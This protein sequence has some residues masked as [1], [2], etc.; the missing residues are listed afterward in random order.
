MIGINGADY[1]DGRGGYNM[2]HYAFD[3]SYG[4]LGGVSV[5]L[6]TGVAVDGF[7]ST[8]M[9]VNIQRVFGTRVADKFVGSNFDDQF[10]GIQGVDY[11]DGGLGSDA[12]DY[13]NDSVYGGTAGIDVN[14]G[15]GTIKDG[16]GFTDQVTGIE[17]VS[18]TK[19]KDK[20][21][22]DSSNNTFRGLSE[23][24]SFDGGNGTDWVDYSWDV[25][26]GGKL[27]VTA[28][29]TTGLG[30]DGFGFK[31]EALSNIENLIGTEQADNFTG[32]TDSNSL[33]G[34]GG[35]DT[36]DGKAG[37]DTLY[38]GSGND[39]FVLR[40]GEANGDQILDFS[41]NGAAVG[42]SIRFV[43]Y[44]TKAQGATVF[45]DTSNP[46]AWHVRSADGLVEDIFWLQNG[47]SLH[48]SDF[49]FG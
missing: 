36:L 39:V 37:A 44:G 9:L 41:G 47:A 3:A 13:T 16:F 25:S 30:S 34:Q 5:N 1:I 27:G 38:G 6:A 14:L 49:T 24:D 40:R 10:F 45:R 46:L 11:F 18:G 28:N 31:N 17:I 21:V 22:G 32:S 26:Y 29:L 43:G 12:A 8:D 4:G 48:T 23:V 33:Y 19:F 42:D 35:S 15:A 2:V 20:F 7:G